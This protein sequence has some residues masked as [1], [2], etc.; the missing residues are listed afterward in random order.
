MKV[1]IN[2]RPFVVPDDQVLAK[3]VGAEI[4]SADRGDVGQRGTRNG[5][6]IS[7]ESD[8]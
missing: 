6:G 2:N 1:R 5:R 8:P 3:V 4:P 7:D